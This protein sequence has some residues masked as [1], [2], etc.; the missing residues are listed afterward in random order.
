MS[1]WYV[2]SALGFYAVD[3]VSGNYAFGTPLFDRAIIE[4]G[5]GKSLV[6]ET[7]RRSPD[8]KYV[9]SIEFNGSPYSK[10]WF[11]HADIVNGAAIVFTMGSQPDKQFG[12]GD[13][14]APPSLTAS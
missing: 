2:I 1:A 13:D 8:D 10:L 4:L 6:L 5:N 12:A 9:Q 3:P 14:A 11:R 7:K